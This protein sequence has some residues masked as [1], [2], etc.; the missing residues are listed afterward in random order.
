MVTVMKSIREI[1][2]EFDQ[3]FDYKLME[4]L[5]KGMPEKMN[6]F[7]KV[8]SEKRIDS[9]LFEAEEDGDGEKFLAVM[10]EML[11]LHPYKEHPAMAKAMAIVA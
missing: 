10:R 2:S 6:E 5:F 11:N 9:Q 1:K 8:L 3:A 7:C 4:P